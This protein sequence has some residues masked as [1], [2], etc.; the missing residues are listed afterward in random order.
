MMFDFQSYVKA[1]GEIKLYNLSVYS[2]SFGEWINCHPHT[3]N[4]AI[5]LLLQ[6][7]ENPEV[8][9]AATMALKD[10]T[11]ENLEH[12]QPF[13]PQILSA[14]QVKI[15]PYYFTVV[16]FMTNSQT[17]LLVKMWLQIQVSLKYNNFKEFLKRSQSCCC[18]YYV[19]TLLLTCVNLS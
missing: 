8:A 3:L 14:C 18:Y 9:T 12:I 15:F 16:T 6:G 5:P 1:C 10:V 19:Y 2:G 7:M 13:I 17:V 11:R 4:A